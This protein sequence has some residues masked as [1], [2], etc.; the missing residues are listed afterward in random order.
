M[1]N[2]RTIKKNIYENVLLCS[3]LK[4]NPTQTTLKLCGMQTTHLL[5]YAHLVSSLSRH[6]RAFRRIEASSC[7]RDSRSCRLEHPR[8]FFS[9]FTQT[10]KSQRNRSR[11]AV[12]SCSHIMRVGRVSITRTNH[13]LIRGHV[14]PAIG[15]NE[16]SMALAPWANLPK[17]AGRA[18]QTMP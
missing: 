6:I 9:R 17:L 15:G 3:L 11:S 13:S 10:G 16:L 2:N 4:K 12:S 8:Q 14:L 7:Y 18:D 1:L 5:M